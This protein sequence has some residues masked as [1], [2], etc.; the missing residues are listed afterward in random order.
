MVEE[1]I[2]MIMSYVGKG[3]TESHISLLTGRHDNYTRITANPVNFLQY[4]F[5]IQKMN[6]CIDSKKSEENV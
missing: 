2:N 6:R 5:R 1:I 4:Y 3:K